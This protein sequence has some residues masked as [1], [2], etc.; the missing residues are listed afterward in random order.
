MQ[1]HNSADHDDGLGQY[2]HLVFRGQDAPLLGVPFH[3][4]RQMIERVGWTGFPV[5]LA[6]HR[7]LNVCGAPV[8]YAELHAHDYAEI[9][10][11]IGE[12]DGLVYEIG[13]GNELYKV[14]SPSAIWIPAK[15]HHSANAL[16][17]SGFFVCMIL[18]NSN[19]S[20][21]S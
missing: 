11:I 3:L 7:V 12:E 2:A 19:E 20:Q 6:V 10:I 4:N 17:G 13:L 1:S 21:T 5:H 14:S 9:N 18:E 8:C 16:R 15:L